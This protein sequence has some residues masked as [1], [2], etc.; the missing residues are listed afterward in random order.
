[1]G[2]EKVSV[3]DEVPSLLALEYRLG[4]VVAALSTKIKGQDGDPT[5]VIMKLS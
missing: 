1:V 3:D 2:F 5:I 4:K